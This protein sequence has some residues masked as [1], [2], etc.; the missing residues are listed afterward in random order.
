MDVPRDNGRA[1]HPVD[2]SLQTRGARSDRPEEGA[3]QPEPLPCPQRKPGAIN[4]NA[5]AVIDHAAQ[6][7]RTRIRRSKNKVQRWSKHRHTWATT[8]G[9]WELP[10]E[11]QASIKVTEVRPTLSGTKGNMENE[12]HTLPATE[13]QQSSR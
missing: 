6:E 10:H 7:H 8:V 4:K 9:R 11:N 13:G 3:T 5:V 1:G 2:K 12:L